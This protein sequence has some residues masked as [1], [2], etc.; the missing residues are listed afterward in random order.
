[1][2]GPW[3]GGRSGGRI[4]IEVKGKARDVVLQYFFNYDLENMLDEP[5]VTAHIKQ[6]AALVHQAQVAFQ[7]FFHDF[8]DLLDFWSVYHMER[9]SRM[10]TAA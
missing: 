1:M 6:V 5:R 3:T 7:R 2:E 9:L 4:G 10:R 8:F